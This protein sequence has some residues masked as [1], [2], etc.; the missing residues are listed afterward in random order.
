MNNLVLQ[1][2]SSNLWIGFNIITIKIQFNKYVHCVFLCYKGSNRTCFFF[3]S[4]DLHNLLHPLSTVAY[5]TKRSVT[6]NSCFKFPKVI[7]NPFCSAFPLL[8]SSVSKNKVSSF[9]CAGHFGRFVTVNVTFWHE[10]A[11][12]SILPICQC[13]I[14]LVLHCLCTGI[15]WYCPILFICVLFQKI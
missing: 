14:S 4:H 6:L 10:G 12:F 9:F 8:L 7:Y 15:A 5:F 13:N 1:C 11:I 2:T 3:S